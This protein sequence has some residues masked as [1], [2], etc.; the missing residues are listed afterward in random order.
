[1]HNFSPYLIGQTGSGKSNLVR[2]EF[3]PLAP[4][5]FVSDSQWE[6]EDGAIFYNFQKAV[7][8]WQRN[9]DKD[10]H[11]IFRSE[12]RQE[13]VAFFDLITQSQLRMDLP[14]IAII[15][16]EASYDSKTHNIDEIIDTMYTKGRHG[17][18]NVLTVVQDPTQ[19]HPIIRKMSHLWIVLRIMEASSPIRQKFSRESIEKMA[20]LETILPNTVP[21]CG[22]HYMTNHGCVKP[23]PFKRWYEALR[24]E[25]FPEGKVRRRRHI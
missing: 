4:R 3:L 5:A 17:K 22:T 6:Y 25:G 14:P 18:I 9:I 24:F 11:L 21:V 20:E 10:Y 12:N 13:H 23:D 7:S 2:S 8:F 15:A 1:M 19:V 16:E